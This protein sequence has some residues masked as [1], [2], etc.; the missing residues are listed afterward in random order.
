MSIN[1]K[2]SRLAQVQTALA[3]DNPVLAMS[4]KRQDV[5]RCVKVIRQYG[6][7]TPPVVGDLGRGGHVVLSG[8]CEFQALREIG[9]KSMEA[10]TVPIG[11]EGEGDRLS[12]LLMSLK[13]NP[14]ALS[15]GILIN[16]LFKTG[17][18]TQ[19]QLG[20]LLG[21]SVSWVN[22]RIS[23]VTR[24]EP[25]VM[26]L[27]KLGQI[28]PHSAQ[29]ISRLPA[30]AQHGFS[31]TVVKEG[32]P[33]SSVEALVSAF[34]APA[35]PDEIKGQ[36]VSDPRSTLARLS[37]TALAK[38]IRQ[39]PAGGVYFPGENTDDGIG[40]LRRQLAAVRVRLSDKT[41]T[42]CVSESQWRALRD[43]VAA[44]LSLLDG[45]MPQSPWRSVWGGDSDGH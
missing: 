15:E 21:R 16:Q 28:C 17:Q 42:A 40:R 31:V 26:E 8:E 38:A 2:E 44:L 14:N 33:K 12:L 6:L 35:C 41:A 27:V 23:L 29:E 13:R 20:E 22:K 25:S 19:A 11:G 1:T 5:D 7:L 43:E 4:V 18:Y 30:G 45:K 32:L 9:A 34:N 24:L 39:H 36:I 3:R 37:D 10:I